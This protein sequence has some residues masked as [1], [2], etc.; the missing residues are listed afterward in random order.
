MHE[1]RERPPTVT[2]LTGQREKPRKKT[3]RPNFWHGPCTFCRAGGS[4][5]RG[6]SPLRALA[7]FEVGALAAL[8][9]LIFV[10]VGARRFNRFKLHRK[11]VRVL[12][13][14]AGSLRAGPEVQ[15]ITGGVG[16]E[17]HCVF[18]GA[19]FKPVGLRFQEL[20]LM[21]PGQLRTRITLSRSSCHA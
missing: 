2:Q 16:G 6:R 12:A 20:R 17:G 11:Q 21:E 14:D 7:H 10:R 15:T 3:F 9:L 13:A 8:P 5:P 18:H 4:R 1:K 19:H